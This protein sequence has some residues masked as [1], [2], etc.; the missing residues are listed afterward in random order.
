M[1]LQVERCYSFNEESLSFAEQGGT[2]FRCQ[3]PADFFVF[4]FIANPIL[5]LIDKLECVWGFLNGDR[6]QLGLS[7]IEIEN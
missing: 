1:N 5:N 2:T 3:G 7:L 6:N 4:K